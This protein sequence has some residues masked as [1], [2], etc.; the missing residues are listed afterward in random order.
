MKCHGEEYINEKIIEFG[1]LRILFKGISEH[2]EIGYGHTEINDECDTE[3]EP[4]IVGDS[5]RFVAQVQLVEVGGREKNDK[6]SA[7][8]DHIT[9][10][11]ENTFEIERINQYKKRENDH[12]HFYDRFQKR[13]QE[14]LM[15]KYGDPEVEDPVVNIVQP[16]VVQVLICLV[17]A[18][19]IQ[20][21][22][23]TPEQ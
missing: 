23:G 15:K 21:K 2:T 17:L 20:C 8:N 6:A 4:W 9:L 12:K 18:A 3:P 7:E 14:L 22:K 16:V 13:A 11:Q 10:K 5:L 1:K 19:D